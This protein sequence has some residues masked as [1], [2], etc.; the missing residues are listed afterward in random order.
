MIFM[1]LYS[2]AQNILNLS[3]SE[4]KQ[5]E[6]IHSLFSDYYLVYCE[7]DTVNAG[8]VK[9]AKLTFTDSTFFFSVMLISTPFS[10]MEYEELDFQCKYA[11]FDDG[12]VKGIRYIPREKSEIF[13][14]YLLKEIPVLSADSQDCTD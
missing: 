7:I 13:F 5:I 8:Y 11:I 6:Y 10:K 12:T 2:G 3:V 4:K 1:S 9:S 14:S